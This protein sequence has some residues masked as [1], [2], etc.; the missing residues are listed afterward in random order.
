MRN[1]RIAPGVA[2]LLALSATVACGEEPQRTGSV[3][4]L[5]VVGSRLRI[6]APG[7]S[8]QPVVGTLVEMNERE[9]V[10]S[11]SGSDHK[12]IPRSELARVENSDGRR[13][14][15][16]KGALIGAVTGLAFFVVAAAT[17]DSGEGSVSS[18][19]ILGSIFTGATALTGAVIGASIRTERW[20]PVASSD[21][22]L[23]L[24]PTKGRGV[25]AALTW[26][27]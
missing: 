1:H 21:L 16:K 23:G 20:T 12:T 3:V 17:D 5:P 4:A 11:L 26:S 18:G 13:G 25:A 9:I 8:T 24:R 10:L 19:L 6:T 15:G 2:L 7:V 14:H 27:W 22:R